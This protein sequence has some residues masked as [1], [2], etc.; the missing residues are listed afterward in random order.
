M[1]CLC[2]DF[3][4][5]CNACNVCVANF[6]KMVMY[7][8]VFVP[9]LAQSV[10]CAMVAMLV[11]R[12]AMFAMLQSVQCL[13]CLQ[14]LQCW[15]CLQCLLLCGKTHYLQ[16]VC[17]DFRPDCNVCNVFAQIGMF[18]MFAWRPRPDWNVCSV[19]VTKLIN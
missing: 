7:G 14:C 15:Q 6:A 9:T 1:Q 18:A 10:M 2:G 8:F 19:C 11:W 5:D 12:L 4:P 3:R 13:Q 17:G 16:Y